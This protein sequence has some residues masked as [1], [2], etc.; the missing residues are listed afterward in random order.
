MWQFVHFASAVVSS[1][2]C[3]QRLAPGAVTAL[4]V[5]SVL[6]RVDRHPALPV[7]RHPIVTADAPFFPS[8]YSAFPPRFVPASP[9]WKHAWSTLNF[10]T[11][12]RMVSSAFQRFFGNLAYSQT[13]YSSF[14]FPPDAPVC[15]RLR[16]AS[17]QLLWW[18][19]ESSPTLE[20]M[21]A[22]FPG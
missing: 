13:N 1:E 5:P 7:C 8:S 14:R 3:I 9:L 10:Y 20:I 21:S 19:V 4:S 2:L 15:E 16:A 18:Q 6:S 11:T 17:Q 22:G 12:Y